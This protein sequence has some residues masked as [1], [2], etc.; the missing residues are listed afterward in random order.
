MNGMKHKLVVD[1]GVQQNC[2]H[3]NQWDLQTTP[4]KLPER[5]YFH[6]DRK[7]P[8]E[9]VAALRIINCEGRVTRW[10]D[11]RRP[12]WRPGWQGRWP[13]RWLI[14]SSSS[15]NESMGPLIAPG[16]IRNGGPLSKIEETKHEDE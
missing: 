1:E 3:S 8:F 16:R 5:Q 15:L 7:D 6:D 14:D 13:C 2:T 10:R 12:G 9:K 4:T 11:R